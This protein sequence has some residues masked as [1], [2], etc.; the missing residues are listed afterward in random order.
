[1]RAIFTP[2]QLEVG[3]NIVDNDIVGVQLPDGSSD[4]RFICDDVDFNNFFGNSLC[5]GLYPADSTVVLIASSNQTI[6]WDSQFC[7]AQSLSPS[8]CTVVMNNLRTLA[9]VEFDTAGMPGT[10]FE[11]SPRVTVALGGTG[12]GHVTGSGYDCG[13]QCSIDKPYQQ[14]VSLQ[15]TADP[16]SQFIRWQG[17]CSTVPTCTFSAGSATRVQAV[18]DLPG[19]TAKP[20]VTS[21][22]APS[23]QSKLAARLGKISMKHRAGFRVLELPIVLDRSAR[24]TIRL[25][26]R[27]HTI[28][29][30]HRTLHSGRT[31]LRL[32]IPKKLKPG[33]CQ[34]RVR[35]VAGDQ[36][37]TLP[38]SVAIGR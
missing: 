28:V 21:P 8:T 1:V 27:T 37:R 12:H 33:R 13:S 38:A 15:A 32:R 16:G 20:P 18:F 36:V 35:I 7:Y 30:Q 3:L 5:H 29:L 19:A 6:S 9:A 4:S 26:R 17:V 11:I 34:I 14:A 22:T 10:P 2:L 23:V 24:V 31:V 25:S